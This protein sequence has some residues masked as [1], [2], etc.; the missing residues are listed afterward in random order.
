MQ[1]LEFLKVELRERRLALG[2]TLQ[3]GALALCDD[4]E[5][6][7]NRQYLSL[8]KQW[9]Q[10]NNCILLGCDPDFKVPGGRVQLLTLSH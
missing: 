6:H 10:E 9:E 2:L 4:A 3:D 7:R 1:F 8:R 5:Q